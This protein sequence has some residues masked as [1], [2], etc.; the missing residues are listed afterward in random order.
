ME[1]KIISLNKYPVTGQFF[2]KLHPILENEGLI[3]IIRINKGFLYF[4]PFKEAIDNHGYDKRK[5]RCF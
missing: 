4:F 2:S 1:K 3:K 5:S